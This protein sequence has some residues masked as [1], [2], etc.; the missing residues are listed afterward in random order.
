MATALEIK[1]QVEQQ[2]AEYAKTIRT[3]EATNWDRLIPAQ[4]FVLRGSDEITVYVFDEG[5]FRISD[6]TLYEN[7]TLTMQLFNS[8]RDFLE[9]HHPSFFIEFDK[10][11]E[12]EKKIKALLEYDKMLEDLQNL[13]PHTPDLKNDISNMANLIDSKG[14]LLGYLEN[15]RNNLTL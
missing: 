9:T 15:R 1:K 12:K 8:L 13:I 14:D 5:C 2:K 6:D 10:F 4:K 11:T 3:F 7:A